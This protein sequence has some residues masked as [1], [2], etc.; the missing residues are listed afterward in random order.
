LRSFARSLGRR[1][2]VELHDGLEQRDLRALLRLLVGRLFAF[3][4]PGL[5]V[6]LGRLA[7]LRR[8]GV[9]LRGGVGQKERDEDEERGE[10]EEDL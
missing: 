4:I 10:G 5:G 7:L 9:L 3:V 1:L 6:V 2:F 8:L